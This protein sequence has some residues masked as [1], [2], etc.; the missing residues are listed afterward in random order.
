MKYP[1]GIK[2]RQKP[3]SNDKVSYGQR[4]MTL[5]KDIDK[6]NQY[7]L[8]TKKAVI[9]KKPTPVQIVNVDYPSRN[10]AKITEAYFKVP[11]T[12]DY[13][14]IYKG[15]YIDF[16]AKETRN[17]TRFPFINIHAHQVEHMRACHNTGGIVFLIIKFTVYDEVFLYPFEHFVKHWDNF[18]A[19]GR[20]S[21]PYEDIKNE[22]ILLP[23][24][25]NP[26]YDYLAALEEF[27]SEME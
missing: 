1:Q 2:A 16:E 27:Y 3:K 23:I 13:N 21:I 24:K 12:S 14:G 8:D 6:T 18:M 4:G 11:S 19:D 9:H 10:K 17:K 22:S 25:Y 15:K 26:R 20:K 7:Y 5:E